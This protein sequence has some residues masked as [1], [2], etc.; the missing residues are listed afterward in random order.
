[1]LEVETQFA[2]LVGHRVQ[3]AL[4]FFGITFGM[5]DQEMEAERQADK[6]RERHPEL[7]QKIDAYGAGNADLL[8][9]H[10]VDDGDV[11]F[12]AHPCMVRDPNKPYTAE[13]KHF[14]CRDQPFHKSM[15]ESPDVALRLI[16][17]S[18]AVDVVKEARKAFA[19]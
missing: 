15:E 7:S 5:P 12:T 19:S 11:P 1:M 2:P 18:I 8:P 16:A 17:G 13:A 6:M 3:Y 9:I 14:D 10:F 4:V